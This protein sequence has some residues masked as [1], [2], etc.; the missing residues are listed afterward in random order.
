[1]EINTIITG[2]GGQGNVLAS[3]ILGNAAVHK[4]FHV[5]IG[6]TFGLSQRG[7]AVMS[8]VRLF[9]EPK[10]SPLIPPNMAHIIVG[11]EPLEALRITREFA[12][13]ETLFI[14]NS[15]P[16]HPLNVIAGDVDYPDVRWI[17]NVLEQCGSKLY[18]LE[19]TQIAID[20]GG[21]IMLNMLMLGALC[22][23]EMFPL[24]VRD[25]KAVLG[26]TFPKSKLEMNYKA[27]D[28][29]KELIRNHEN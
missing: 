9:R 10:Y 19:G 20:L 4:G 3:Q 11:L 13:P 1:M 2:V 25:I 18:W 28:M 15:R 17:R 12:N 8:H 29:G 27:L 7:G 23:I 14:V 5:S 24:E 6:E 21:P 16:I 26:E 22:A